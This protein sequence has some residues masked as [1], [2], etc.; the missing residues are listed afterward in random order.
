MSGAEPLRD[1]REAEPGTLEPSMEEILASIRRILA[2]GQGLWNGSQGSSGEPEG[3]EPNSRS[4]RLDAAPDATRFS[5]GIARGRSERRDAG[6]VVPRGS[7]EPQCTTTG[8]RGATLA[9]AATEAS[10]AAA[11][12]ALV[13]S[14]FVRNTDLVADL[15]REMIRPLLEA[16]IDEHLPALVE[17]LIAAEI[18][19]IARGE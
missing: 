12:H 6:D 7:A 2:D 17:R 13:A 15:T 16:W 14:R 10:V 3:T 9:S 8:R 4:D 11:F 5:N 1:D 18:A 19:R